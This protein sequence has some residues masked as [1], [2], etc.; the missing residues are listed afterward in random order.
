MLRGSRDFAVRSDYEAFL[1]RLFGELNRTRTTRFEEERAVLRALPAR[2][3]P[4]YERLVVRVA[5][6]STITVKRNLYS[7]PSRLIGERVEVHLYAERLEVH[8][9]QQHVCQ[10][11][12]L[13]GTGLHRIDYRHVIGALLAKP[14]AF[15]HYAYQRDLFPSHRFRLAYDALVRAKSEA[16]A[17]RTYLRLLHLAAGEGETAVEAALAT[18]LIDEVPIT[19]EAVERLVAEGARRLSDPVVTVA[20]VAL[21]CYDS[22]LTAWQAPAW[23]VAA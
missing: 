11:P 21:S 20:P 15:A 14:G 1:A 9:A 10:M 19:V 8:Y 6:S 18:L 13:R 7:V 5:P 23:E 12:R 16:A 2:A 17:A 3:L 4:T 22:L